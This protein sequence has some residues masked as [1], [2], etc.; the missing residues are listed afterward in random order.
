[1]IFEHLLEVLLYLKGLILTEFYVI[2]AILGNLIGQLGVFDDH[3][4]MSIEIYSD[5][6]FVHVVHDPMVSCYFEFHLLCLAIETRS[7][8]LSLFQE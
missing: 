4:S 3:P 7:N 5:H 8:Y 2:K 6:Y 1:M